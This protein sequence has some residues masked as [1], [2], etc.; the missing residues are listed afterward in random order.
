MRT[1]WLLTAALAAATAVQGCSW[2]SPSKEEITLHGSSRKDSLTIGQLDREI[3]DLA[4]RYAMGVAEGCDRI[5][6][7]DSSKEVQ[8]MTHFFKLRNA[9]SAYD[10]VTSGDALEG[11]LDLV[12][13]IELQN[14]V[15]VD[16][17]RLAKVPHVPGV[18]FLKSILGTSREEAWTLTARALTKDQ[19]AKVRKVIHEWRQKHPD[20]QWVAYSR[21]SSGANASV[22]NLLND[23]RSSLGGLLDPFGSAAKSV[24]DTR[25]LAAKAL[26]YSKRLPMLLQWEAE[27]AAMDIVDLPEI[28]HLGDLPG[29]AHSLVTRIAAAMGI[30]LVVAAALLLVYRRISLGWERKLRAPQRPPTRILPTP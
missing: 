8:R 10:V 21:F 11:L 24:D 4:D 27:A 26:F 19:V 18:D 28:Q 17:N 1:S 7:Q 29:E 15:M 9:T 16:E 30:L 3:Q 5:R 13:L 6:R 22:S 25:E 23:I 20:V 2:I 12:T 14:I